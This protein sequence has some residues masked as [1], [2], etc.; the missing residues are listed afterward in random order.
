MGKNI[1]VQFGEC[2]KAGKIKTS[3]DLSALISK[4][5]RVAEDDLKTA[6][7]GI[8]DSRWKWSTIQSYYVMFH[9]ARA[10]LFIKGYRE[11]S[12]YCLRI[13]IDHLYSGVI[14]KYLIDDFQTAKVMRENADYEENF[15]ETGA[16]K[17]V[18]SAEAFLSF[19][20]GVVG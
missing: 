11:K 7:D 9:A 16:R 12:H 10:L 4:E 17:I 3:S 1:A 6:T 20:K 15:S 13:A 19:A 18:K 14:P 5:L 8:K 2:L